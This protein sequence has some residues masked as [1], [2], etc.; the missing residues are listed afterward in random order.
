[1]SVSVGKT[2]VGRYELGRTLGEGTFA[3]VKFARNVETGENVA[4][5]I[6][7]KE[8]VLKHK[9]IAQIK[10]EISTMKLIRHPNV[11]RMYEVMASKTKIY[12]VIEL[13]TGGELFDKIASRGRLKEGD[14]R[15]YFQQLINAV[16]YSHSRGVYHRDLKPENLLLD[17]SGTLK[18]SDFGL[19]ALPQQVRE[20]GL[21]HTTCG[22][23]N[24]VAPEVINNK[25]YDGAKADLWSCGVILFVLMAGYLPFED[26]NLMSLYKKIFKANFSCPSWFSTSAKKLI[27]KILDPN[28]STRITIAELINN[29][30]FKKGYEPPRFETADV[31][32][33]DVNS[34]FNE[35]GDPAQLVVERREERPSVMNAFEL[36]ST[37][38]GLNLGTLFEKQNDSVKRETRFASRLPANEILSKIE[39]AAGPMGFNVQKHNYKLKLQGENPGRKGQ[40]AVAT[41]VFEVTPSLY[42]VELRKSNGDTLEFHKFYHNISNGLK[43]V[44][45][46]PEGGIVEGDEA[47]HRR[48]PDLL[49]TPTASAMREEVR[50]SSAA[51][52]DPPPARSAS[53]PPTPVASSAG[54]S[55]PPG[56]TNVASIDWL[57]GDQVSKVGSSHV[58]P[59]VSQPS[60][61]TNAAGTAANFF[62]PSCRPWER[63]DL[64]CR[65]ATF[66]PST[67][68]SKPK[69]ASSLACARRGW[70]NI[71]MDKIECESCGAHLIF[72]ALTSWSPAEVA[73]AGEAFAEQLDASHQNDCPWRGNSCADSLV[74]F[75]ITP[76]ALVGGFKDRCDGLLQFI[77]LPVIASSAIESMRLTRSAEIDHVLSQSVTILS[78]ELGYKTDS[79]TGIDINH[80]DETCGYS[81]AQKL[82][83][84]C[85]W[86][87]RWLP[88][89]QDWE[90]NSTRSARNAGSTEPNDQFHSQFS[91][92]HQ[93]PCSA[94]VKKEKGK[95]KMRVKDTGCSM[96]SPLLDCSLCGATARIWD[97]RSV[98]RPSHFSLN[99]FD[100]PDTGRKPVLTRGI[101]ATSGINGGLAEGAERDNVEGRDEAS[102]DDRKSLSNAQVDLNLT[103][104]GGLP[105]KHSV[106]PL[107]PEHFNYG[108]IGRDLMIGQ[109]TGSELGG[110][111]ASFESRGPSSRK[112]NLEEGGSTADKLINRLQPADSIEGTVIDRDGDEVDDAAQ[113]S[114]T[115]SKRPRGFNLFDVNRPSSS[116]AGPSRNLSFDLDIDVNRFDTSKAEGPSALQNPSAR[117]SMRAS[118]VIAMDTV[119]GVEENSMES[120]EYH[121]CDGDDVNKP[122]RALRS[123][124]MSDTLDFNYSNQAQQSNFLQPAAESNAREI[125]GSSMNG[126]EEV[127]NAEMVPAF[128]RDQLSL[129]VSGG[130]VGMGASHEAEIHGID[131]SEHKTGSVVGDVDPIPEL[132]ETMG[133][134]G[135]SAPGPGLMDEFVP[136]E[137]GREDPN[138]DSQD[139]RADS[140]SKI[141]G[142]TRAD[143]VESREK[144]SHATGQENSA[145]PSL[146]CN[147]RVYSGIDASKEEVTGTM[148]I[149]DDYDPGNGASN[150]E[151]DYETDL[152]E[153]DPIKHHN[154]YCPWVNGD[155]AAACCTNTSSSTSST[156]L[157]GWQLT[158]DAIETLQSLGQAQNQT[159][160]S[161]SAASLYKDD[162]IAPSRKLLKRAKHSKC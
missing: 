158:V 89:V 114:G 38:Q 160:Q 145:H 13:V 99:N 74:Q 43:D 25:G 41:E 20:D 40:L 147:A 72:T 3:K 116:G 109:P 138:G 29:E 65:L 159:M 80:Q 137:V 128:A 71:D 108:G 7:D 10:R 63:G 52:P 122:S 9:M 115:R 127:L 106:M 90:E 144:M 57:G 31:N 33:D 56:Q 36:I 22:T 151:N 86:E 54:A 67:W 140:G 73:N 45:W 102:T 83:S 142:S 12:I 15:K 96:R 161:D 131:V 150:G 82:I 135:E 117:D 155:V 2:R 62:E 5:K 44:M 21:L 53:N 111:A 97:F 18:V 107:M 133:H 11:I 101:S 59:H 162:H 32:L 51:P 58:A 84:L 134:T 121:P 34:I 87:P 143:S 26:S 70:V 48:L 28:P 61:S 94:S 100:V 112:R 77:S 85:G 88:N 19:S 37:S 46:K 156:A 146:S 148:L 23:P 118:S 149:N 139:I 129:G 49:P 81:Q 42:M 98:P 153:F 130:S 120:V 16:D 6:L 1:M 136:E 92:H 47:H 154:N 76:S 126:G 39:A 27:K 110:H 8:K 124:G 4:I 55:S 35:S 157:S 64:L 14:A 141:C 68:A 17:A 50:S 103:M 79:T 78:G 69:A 152:P 95:G 91:E 60:L 105:S 30:W 123:D 132:I 125:G 66:K 119:H 93:N 24:Y 75:H 104:A 113:D